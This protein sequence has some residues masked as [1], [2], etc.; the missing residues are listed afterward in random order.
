MHSLFVVD[1]KILSNMIFRVTLFE[2]KDLV[3][4]QGSA[5]VGVNP[6]LRRCVLGPKYY[7]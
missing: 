4:T 2:L 3:N 6:F 5:C 7:V 1:T